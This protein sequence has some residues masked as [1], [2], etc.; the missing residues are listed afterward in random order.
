MTFPIPRNYED[1]KDVEEK[2]R[3]TACERYMEVWKKM[4]FL[5]RFL[6]D[7]QPLGATT[8]RYFK[9]TMETKFLLGPKAEIYTKSGVENLELLKL[10][11]PDK[12]HSQEEC[13]EV[14]SMSDYVKP[15][16][17]AYPFDGAYI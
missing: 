5:G 12:D 9:M 2:R 4:Q 7:V 6:Y 10:R 17:A 13:S 16:F 1:T 14:E 8:G 11:P 3:E 15:D